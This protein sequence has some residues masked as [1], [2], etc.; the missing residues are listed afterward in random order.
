MGK[1]ADL[2]VLDGDLIARPADIGKVRLVFKDGVGYDA[3][4]LRQSTRGLVG[5]R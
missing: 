3:N 5:I 1:R 2:A 4:K